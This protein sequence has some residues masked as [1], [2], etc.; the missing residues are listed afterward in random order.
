[1]HPLCLDRE[2]FPLAS[3][4]EHRENLSLSDK[5]PLEANQLLASRIKSNDGRQDRHSFP[6]NISEGNNRTLGFTIT[7]EKIVQIDVVADP[8]HLASSTSRFST[9]D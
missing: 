3:P 4:L 7:E 6:K 9:E 2:H 5:T 1:M 8:D